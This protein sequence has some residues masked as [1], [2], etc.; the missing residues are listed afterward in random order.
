MG[1]AG[2]GVADGDLYAAA[3]VGADRARDGGACGSRLLV[4]LGSARD[5]SR[6]AGADAAPR[7]GADRAHGRY[8][9]ATN[10]K[11]VAAVAA[12]RP[13]SRLRP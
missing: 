1:T 8:C 7:V 12:A 6:D 3:G 10:A 11:R 2:R 4:R 5:G 9:V 13:A